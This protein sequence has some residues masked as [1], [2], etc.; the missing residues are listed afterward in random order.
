MKKKNDDALN[1]SKQLNWHQGAIHKLRYALFTT[2][3]HCLHFGNDF[4]TLTYLF[5]K[6]GASRLVKICY[7]VPARLLDTT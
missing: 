6:Q 3:R 5:A 2:P 1:K 4:T 7:L